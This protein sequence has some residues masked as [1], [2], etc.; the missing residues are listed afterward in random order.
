M[1]Q[2]F[3]YAY[4][5]SPER[6]WG[7]LRLSGEMNVIAEPTPPKVLLPN[8]LMYYFNPDVLS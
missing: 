4:T 1:L 5:A 7:L 3:F 6:E 2:G 8:V